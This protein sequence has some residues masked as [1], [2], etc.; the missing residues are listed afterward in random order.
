ML[1]AFTICRFSFFSPV[2]GNKVSFCFVL[3]RLVWFSLFTALTQTL[4]L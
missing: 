1:L 4:I 2:L 3:L